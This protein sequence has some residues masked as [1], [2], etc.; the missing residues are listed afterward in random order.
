MGT[1]AQEA[2]E[3][4]K[5]HMQMGPIT[6]LPVNRDGRQTYVGMQLDRSQEGMAVHQGDYV[7]ALVLQP[8]TQKTAIVD[9]STIKAPLPEEIDMSLEKTYR[10]LA[11][12]LGWSVKTQPR[13]RVFYDLLAKYSHQPSPKL[14][15]CL[16]RVLTRMQQMGAQKLEIKKVTG[17]PRLALFTDGGFESSTGKARLGFVIRLISDQWKPGEVT[18]GSNILMFSTKSHKQLH[19]SSSGPELLALLWGLK[20]LWRLQYL[21]RS[22][23]NDELVRPMIIIDSKPVYDQIRKKEAV[24]EPKLGPALLYAIQEMELLDAVLGWSPRRYQEADVLTKAVWPT[25]T[26]PR[27]VALREEPRPHLV[28]MTRGDRRHWGRF[29]VPLMLRGPAAK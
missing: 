15:L 3:K 4:I 19:V 11:G 14:L 10:T 26:Q 17:R 21:C 2:I 22:L 8:L 23:W 16:R 5:P 20:N 18:D 24:S 25:E 1:R 9:S 7:S 27:L 28:G 12:W 29:G 13:W 6:T